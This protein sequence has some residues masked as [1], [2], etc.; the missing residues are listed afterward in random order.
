MSRLPCK[1][2]LKGT[3]TTPFCEKWHPPECLFYKSKSGCRFGEKCSYAHRQVEQQ[4]SKRSKKNGVKSAVAILKKGDWHENVWE[5]VINH[6]HDRSGRPDKKTSV[7]KRIITNQYF[8]RRISFKKQ[9]CQ[10]YDRFLRGRPI[11]YI[12]HEHVRVNRRSWTAPDLS[13][14]FTICLH[15]DGFQD[16]D[17]RWEQALLSASEITTEIWSWRD[18]TRWK[19]VNLF[20]LLRKWSRSS[21]A[22]LSRI[23]DYGEKTS[24]RWSGRATG[25]KGWD[26]GTSQ[27]SVWEE[28]Q[29]GKENGRMLTVESKWAVLKRILL[30][31]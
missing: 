3:C 17:T 31:I 30:Q 20:S 8:R 12:I 28:C 22:K 13:D 23:E 21:S 4:P 26:R 11:G 9:H 1:D 5:L 10:K 25:W 29:R 14:V 19:Y 6:G 16:F 18:C 7:L 2:Y 27:M 15:D 24:I